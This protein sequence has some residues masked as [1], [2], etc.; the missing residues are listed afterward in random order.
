M[1]EELY[2]WE[3]AETGVEIQNLNNMIIETS[4]IH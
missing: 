4:V 2:Y 1:C 3:L